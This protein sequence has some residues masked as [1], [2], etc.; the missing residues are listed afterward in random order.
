MKRDEMMLL[1]VVFLLGYFASRMFSTE[2]VTQQMELE[3]QADAQR[4]M[5]AA[6]TDYDGPGRITPIVGT[7][8]RQRQRGR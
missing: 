4:Y 2:G 6:P 1:V 3:G 8:T 5:W 7:S